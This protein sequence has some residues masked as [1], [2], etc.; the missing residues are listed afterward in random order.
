MY[1]QRERDI[2]SSPMSID[3]DVYRYPYRERDIN[4]RVER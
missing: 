2:G 1:L 3:L 4:T